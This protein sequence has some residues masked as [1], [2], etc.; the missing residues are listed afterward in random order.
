[1]RLISK[2]IHIHRGIS[3]LK[4]RLAPS[5]IAGESFDIIVDILEELQHLTY[6]GISQI[7]LITIGR[8]VEFDKVGVVA[9]QEA[10]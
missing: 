7:Q 2:P 6:F 3:Q 9:R 5:L 8:R 4:I 10:G 1:M